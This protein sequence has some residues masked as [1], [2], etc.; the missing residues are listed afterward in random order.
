MSKGQEVSV[1]PNLRFIRNDGTR[2]S[3]WDIDCLESVA[4]RITKKNKDKKVKDVLTNSA[5]Y[6]V[7]DQRQYFEK[8]IANKGN[9]NGYYIVNYGDF[10]Y[11][12]RISAAAPVGPISKNKIGTGVMSPLYTVFRFYCN[13]NSFYEQYF[14][15]TKWHNYLR[16]IANTGARHD[17]ISITSNE[18][19]A[20]PIPIPAKEEQQ[21]IAD[22]LISID[23][24]I[25][26]Q[27]QKI[28]ALKEHKKGLMQKLF[29]AEGETVP[30]LRFPEFQ[31]CS[32]W[33]QQSL[34]NVAPLQRGFDL[35]SHRLKEGCI[36]VVYSNGVQ[37]FHNEGKAVAPGLITGRSGTIGKIHYI[38]NG[39]YWPH[40]TTLWV[41]T[42]KGNFPKFVYYLF[43]RINVSQFT[44]GSGVPTLNRNLV[45]AFI[46][47]LPELAEEQQKVA[48]CLTS[49]DELITA[50][51]QKIESLKNH[52]KGLMQQLFP[53]MENM[54]A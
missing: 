45:H 44:S 47:N 10:V 52:K 4:K 14:R 40:N 35:P 7:V 12:P 2:F 25:T 36:P 27:T 21:K 39:K 16:T 18:F 6:G 46:A 15:S 30:E 26:A 9:L 8:D 31:N 51:T 1:A 5:V 42:F 20:M 24:L 13:D 53:A 54:T 17:R 48:D 43:F 23:E 50:Q 33:M 28:E 38:E 37:N 22:C 3:D 41:T 34:S 19:M 11:N 49:I 29:P 32:V